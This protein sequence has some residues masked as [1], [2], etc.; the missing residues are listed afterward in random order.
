MMWTRSDWFGLVWQLFV[1][2]GPCEGGLHST[3]VFVELIGI[4]DVAV[5]LCGCLRCGEVHTVKNRCL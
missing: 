2:I 3:I 4:F 5:F 1:I